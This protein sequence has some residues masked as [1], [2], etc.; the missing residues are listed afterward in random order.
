MHF[1][2]F[3]AVQTVGKATELESCKVTDF[4]DIESGAE[5][6]ETAPFNITD[7]QLPGHD[8]AF[9]L[10]LVFIED[11][12]STS[13]LWPLSSP[14]A[15]KVSNSWSVGKGSFPGQKVRMIMSDGDYSFE[16]YGTVGIAKNAG[17]SQGF[18]LGGAEGDYLALPAIKGLYLTRIEWVSGECSRGGARILKTADDSQAPGGEAIS[19]GSSSRGESYIWN[20]YG[21]E[22]ETSYKICFARTES[23]HFQKLILRYD[24]KAAEDPSK[25]F[26]EAGEDQ[27]P[28]FSR[29]G[30]HYGD[31]EI[32][33]VPV[34]MTIS[35]PADGSDAL[36]IIQDAIDKVQ[37]PGAVLLK[38]GL[39]NVSNR[40]NLNRSG[41][42]LRG[43]GEGKT[44]IR[45][46][47]TSR[48]GDP[49][50]VSSLIVM[51]TSGKSKLS[52]SSRIIAKYV[53]VGQDV[54]SGCRSGAIRRR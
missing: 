10:A 5:I 33:D 13:L 18:R 42:V 34:R 24:V 11:P 2:A 53:P 15:D 20:L 44:V 7:V 17:G 36:K 43:E 45:C 40:I 54:G 26:Q 32:P 46:T 22:K 31:K 14:V 47:D 6:V 48:E 49:G 29:V 28:D 8:S 39:Y 12:T 16:A 21:S 23:Q 52:S 50:K 41:V 37:T 25:D 9:E 27:I 30:Y 4:G 3:D 51:G 38:E 35:A 1:E 19:R